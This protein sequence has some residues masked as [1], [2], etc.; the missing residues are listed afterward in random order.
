M[1]I[2]TLS[3][4]HIDSN[5]TDDL[6]LGAH[7]DCDAIIM[8]GDLCDG[9]YTDP[10]EWLLSEFFDDERAKLLFVAGNH[11]AY[12]QGLD[13]VPDYLTR[14]ADRTGIQILHRSIIEIAGQRFVG[15]PLWSDF[16]PRLDEHWSDKGDF[17]AVPDLTPDSWRAEHRCDRTWLEDVIQAGDVVITHHAP[18]FEGL[19]TEMQQNIQMRMLSSGYYTDLEDL[20][21]DRAPALW[22]HGHTHV[23]RKYAVGATRMVTNARGRGR[24][25]NFDPGLVVEIDTYAPP[26]PGL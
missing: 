10:S 21:V 18:S 6:D 8:S 19:A 17:A 4:L 20:I 3:D 26:P 7:P 11:E 15:A 24:N 1:K 2:W 12:G 22:V 5:H 16:S 9:G 23:T 13:L 25:Y 14:L